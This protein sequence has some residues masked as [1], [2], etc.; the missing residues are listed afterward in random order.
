VTESHQSL[1]VISPSLAMTE[2]MKTFI[3]WEVSHS[4]SGQ[5]IILQNSAKVVPLLLQQIVQLGSGREVGQQRGNRERRNE[6]ILRRGVC[7]WT[8]IQEA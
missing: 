7:R 4:F 2:E 6:E 5:Q 1:A 8:G 3:P